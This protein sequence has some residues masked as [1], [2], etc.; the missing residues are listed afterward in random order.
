MTH[1]PHLDDMADFKHG[2]GWGRC[3]KFISTQ[4]K[5]STAAACLRSASGQLK[6]NIR[7]KTGK[8]VDTVS[9]EE[10]RAVGVKITNAKASEP[11]GEEVIRAR[12]Q[13]VLCSG[14]LG[15]PAILERSG[16]GNPKVLAKAGIDRRVELPGVGEG[17]Q[18][19]PVG[20]H[21]AS[22]SLLGVACPLE[23]FCLRYQRSRRFHA[24]RYERRGGGS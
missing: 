6:P 24:W 12:K 15:T 7:L 9:F 23:L 8:T 5:R 20:P 13:V 1:L 3:Q 14:A 18:D 16:I 22:T 10:D 11:G 17:Y 4:G 21:N 19:H 2:A